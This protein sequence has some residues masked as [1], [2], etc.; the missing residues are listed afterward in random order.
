MDGGS[1]SRPFFHGGVDEPEYGFVV[2]VSPEM[3][4]VFQEQESL[5]TFYIDG[6]FR[7]V[8]DGNFSQL[9]IIHWECRG[10]VSFINFYI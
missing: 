10:H 6:T 1:P 8:P 5:N 4:D 2:F 3:T 9:L 7:I